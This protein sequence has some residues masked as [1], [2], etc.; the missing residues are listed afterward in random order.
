MNHKTRMPIPSPRLHP[1]DIVREIGFSCSSCGAKYMAYECSDVMFTGITCPTC[2]CKT[3][4]NRLSRDDEMDLDI[5][6]NEARK[7]GE[8]PK[9]IRSLDDWKKYRNG[10]QRRVRKTGHTKH[11]INKKN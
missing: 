8:K 10:V 3:H 2:D 6:I 7:R 11:E 5:E 4:G 9:N 1:N